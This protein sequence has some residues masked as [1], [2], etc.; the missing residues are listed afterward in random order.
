MVPIK[1]IIYEIFETKKYEREKQQREKKCVQNL[2]VNVSW[3]AF[4]ML[5]WA[6]MKWTEEEKN[7][8]KKWNESI[9]NS[10][11]ATTAAVETWWLVQKKN[12]Y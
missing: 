6:V 1:Q 12:E 11:C 3:D 7:D 4:I 9:R 10:C 2:S 8:W 5:I